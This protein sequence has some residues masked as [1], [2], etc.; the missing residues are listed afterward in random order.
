MQQYT[1]YNLCIRSELALPELPPAA[2]TEAPDVTVR[3]GTVA[4]DALGDAR[5]V[6]PHAWAG[7]SGVLLDVPAVVRLL[8]RDGRSIVVDPA[9]GMDEDSVRLFLL[10]AALGTL[11]QQRRYLVLHGNAVR[12]GEQCMVCVGPAGAGKSTLAAGFLRR[13]HEVLA[14]DVVP[15][16]A[17]G[18]ALPGFPR[19]KLWQDAAEALRIDTAPLRRVRPLFAKFNLPVPPVAPRPLPVRWIYVLESDHRA[20]VRIRPVQ[21]IGRFQPLHENTYRRRLMA[22]MALQSWH[23]QRCGALAGRVRLARVTRPSAGF[24]LDALMDGLMADMAAHP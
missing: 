20:G 1:A 4:V 14:D 23:L 10:G 8:V 19:I 12:V 11:L 17:Q 18:R 13:G 7:P 5:Q 9:E 2:E 15:V 16:D 21:G 22:G 3:L 6:G 24:E